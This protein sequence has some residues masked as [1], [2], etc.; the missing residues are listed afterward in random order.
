[1]D[2]VSKTTA[3]VDDCFFV[4]IIGGPT[5]WANRTT[6]T[7][8]G[9]NPAPPWDV[10]SCKS[11]DTCHTN[12]YKISISSMTIFG[13]GPELAILRWNLATFLT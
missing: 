3:V 10:R 6:H 7:V 2:K 12:W 8:D 11:W 13:G 4:D 5:K 1:V 9:R